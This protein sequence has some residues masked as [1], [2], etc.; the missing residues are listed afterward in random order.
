MFNKKLAI[1]G[2][3]GAVGRV[4]IELLD[5]MYPGTKDLFLV[6]SKR[7]AGKS[8]L[9]GKEEFLIQDIEDFDFS[10]VDIAF[11]SAGAE[12]AEK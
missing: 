7:S 10:Q 4:F 9:C 11:F 6:A 1:I 5:E 3:S 2:A 8:M 12:I